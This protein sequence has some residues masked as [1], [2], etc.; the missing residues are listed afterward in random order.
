MA[1]FTI[2]EQLFDWRAPLSDQNLRACSSAAVFKRAEIYAATGAVQPTHLSFLENNAV[3]CFEAS[4]MGAQRYETQV[5]VRED[6]FIEGECDCPSASDGYF[7]KHQVALTLVLRGLLGGD[8]A[9]ATAQTQ[10]KLAAAAKRAQTQSRHGAELLA[11]LQGQSAEVLARRLWQWSEQDRGLKTELKAWA[12]Q[13]AAGSKPRALNTAISE[14]LKNSKSF[15]GRRDASLYA[16]RAAKVL[17]MLRPWLAQDP[18]ALQALCEHALKRLF[19]VAE[20]ADDSN[21][22]I[23]DLMRDLFALLI[24]ALAAAP[25]EAKW[26]DRWEALC[27]ADP[28]GLADETALMQAAGPAVQARWLQGTR[29]RWLD[30]LEKQ[31]TLPR[32]GRGGLREMLTGDAAAYQRWRERRSLRQRYL[33]ALA[34]QQDPQALLEAMRSS[35]EEAQEYSELVA[36]CEKLGKFREALQ[37][38]QAAVKQFPDER[39]CKDDLLRCYER[40]GWDEEALALRRERLEARPSAANYGELLEAAVRAGRPL[41]SYRAELFDWAKAREEAAPPGLALASPLNAPG[42]VGRLVSTRIEWLLSEQRHGEALALVQAPNRCGIALLQALAL[43]LPAPLHPDAVRLLLRV[44]ETVMPREQTPYRE[45]L[46]LAHAALQRMPRLQA[47]QWLAYLK[48]TYKARRNFIA[49]LPASI[50]P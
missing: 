45:S 10:K 21:G 2:P 50:E 5:E 34:F 16:Q 30:W 11:F 40:D 27:D 12:A 7:C 19:K 43:Q 35:A 39:V 9:D 4:V 32:P 41:E 24:Q 38:A 17:D 13:A 8:T 14:L 26:F 29:Q 31:P 36:C 1:L 28:W 20:V 46:R 3:I 22:S 18:A 23:G 49:G 44:F 47:L 6:L 33:A 42:P 48:A 37:A 25:P 15:L